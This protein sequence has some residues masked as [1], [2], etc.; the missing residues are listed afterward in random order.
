LNA[1]GK[2]FSFRMSAYSHPAHTGDVDGHL[3]YPHQVIVILIVTLVGGPTWTGGFGTT[4]L[5]WFVG[6]EQPAF[7][8]TVEQASIT[9]YKVVPGASCSVVV[10]VKVVPLTITVGVEL[11]GGQSW[12]EELE[13]LLELE[14]VVP[15]LE[16]ELEELEDELRQAGDCGK[17]VV[18]IQTSYDVTSPA[19][20]GLPSVFRVGAVQLRATVAGTDD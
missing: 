20:T 19:V 8:G 1:A 6:D 5:I 13:E 14:L 2:T 15:E 18:D 3:K 4:V 11:S 7:A 12:L 17:G 16:D 10:F 9:A